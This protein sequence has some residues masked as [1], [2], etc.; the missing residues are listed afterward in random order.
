[1]IDSI[2]E[3]AVRILSALLAVIML[4]IADAGAVDPKAPIACESVADAGWQQ[5][6]AEAQS[7]VVKSWVQR[8]PD[9]HAVFESAPVARNPFA[10][11]KDVSGAAAT[12]GFV[13]ARDVV[14]DV[15][16][17][18]DPSA[19]KIAYTAKAFRFSQDNKSWTK[20]QKNG[21]LVALEL[22]L[23]NGNWVIA[24]KSN[25]FSVLLP[26]VVV[27]IP[28]SDEIPNPAAWP[29]NRC[30]APKHWEGKTCV[31]GIFR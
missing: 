20:P 9:W 17:G 15:K 5:A 7:F 27:R 24:D 8:G 1:M 13:W 25:E 22:T 2:W 28:R 11:G 21:V 30:R 16:Q 31:A 14:C 26:D 29:D 18:D 19:V 12:R 23:K 10:I 6:V 3:P 4:P